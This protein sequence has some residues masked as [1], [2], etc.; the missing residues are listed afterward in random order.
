MKM[1]KNISFHNKLLLSF[2]FFFPNT[3]FNLLRLNIIFN[4]FVL[5]ILTDVREIFIFR[6]ED[7]FFMLCPSRYASAIEALSSKPKINT[8][9]FKYI[10]KRNMIMAPIEPYMALYLEK[11][12]I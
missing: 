8:N 2:Y 7:V 5:S 11:C 3:F 6:E 9:E 12:N 10:H 1:Q 4:L